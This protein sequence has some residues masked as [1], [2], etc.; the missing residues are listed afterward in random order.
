MSL[1]FK[2]LSIGS[3]SVE[4]PVLLAP[5]AGY[6]DSCF[7]RIAREHGAGV[8][9]TE[10]ISAAGL[11]R[12]AAKTLALLE[13]DEREQPLGVQIFG[14]DP[15]EMAEGAR[16]AQDAG[17]SLIDI[18]MGCPAQKVCR[19]GAGASLLRSP[20][21]VARILEAVRRAVSCA[22]T[23]K[24]RLGW[25]PENITASE[26]AKIA[27]ACG[28]DAVTVHP[29]VRSQGFAGLADWSWVARLKAERK[30]PIVGNGD[31]ASAP[32]AFELLAQ[33]ACDAVMIGRA[34]RGNPWIFSG[35][36][37]LLRGQPPVSPSPAERCAVMEKHLQAIC[38]RYAADAAANRVRI[39]F[40]HYVKGL[41]GAA[42]F[43][44]ALGNFEPSRTGELLNLLRTI[45]DAV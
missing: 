2:P 27:E 36:R 22:L 3:L 43:R 41:P 42:A 17:A 1:S 20:E 35:I 8:V 26:I 34:S 7:R 31:V 18:N 5:M 24:I 23:V 6:T 15:S 13:F 4:V 16:I 37:S 44:R 25:D 9:F 38:E 11:V 29:R 10:M 12:R 14:A 28:A 45:L 32:R 30:I 21:R 33:G 40:P 39:L 19:I